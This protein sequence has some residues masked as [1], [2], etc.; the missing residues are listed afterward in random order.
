MASPLHG[1][2]V[3]ALV[4]TVALAQGPSRRVD[5]EFDAASIKPNHSGST[6][7][8][9]SMPPVGTYRATNI[10]LRELIVDAHRVRR[11]QIEGGPDWIDSD[12][13]DIVARTGEGAPRDRMHV[14]LQTLLA[15]RFDLDFHRQTR[16]RPVY[17]LMVVREDGI[18]APAL[19]RSK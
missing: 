16:E 10:T 3:A 12:R 9:A 8:S 1:V 11:F 6:R 2:A 7:T 4:G 5:R 18:P 15:D 14:M 17:A 19:Q 13:F